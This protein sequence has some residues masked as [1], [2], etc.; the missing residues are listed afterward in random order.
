MLSEAA[1]AE[2]HTRPASTSMRFQNSQ[3]PRDRGRAEASRARGTAGSRGRSVGTG[4]SG[5]TNKACRQ[6][7]PSSAKAF[8]AATVRLHMDKSAN[9]VLLNVEDGAV[10]QGG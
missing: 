6:R 8:N 3:T 7:W 2:G 4:L 10:M 1:Q 5:T 9:V